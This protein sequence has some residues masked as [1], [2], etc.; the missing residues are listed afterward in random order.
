MKRSRV[1]IRVVMLSAWLALAGCMAW[2]QSAGCNGQA[3]CNETPSL[4][5]TVTSFRTSTSDRTKIVSATV[6]LVNRTDRPLMLGYVTRSGVATDD[7]GNRYV[8]YGQNGVRGIGEIRSNSRFDNKF[9]LPPGG[10][11]DTRFE[12]IWRYSRRD[13]YGEQFSLDLAIREIEPVGTNQYRLGAEHALHFD[14]L[15]N[16]LRTETSA[17]P[18]APAGSAVSTQP[19]AAI[20]ASVPDPCTGKQHCYFAGPF[21]AEIAQITSARVGNYKDHVIRVNVRF[22]NVSSEPLILGYTSG[23]SI[24]TD[25]LGN[26]YYWGSLNTVDK[27]ATGIGTVSSRGANSSFV[28]NPGQ[29]RN[30]TFQLTRYRPGNKPLGTQFTWEV[31]VEQLEVLSPEHVRTTR[32]FALNFTDIQV[33]SYGAASAQSAAEAVQQLKGLFGGG[34]KK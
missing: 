17:T 6:R 2:G 18:V 11:G 14:G 32:E 23:S 30:A 3:F 9:T 21:S 5:A 15:T 19:G 27:S 13:L 26:R 24:M 34:K 29:S 28:L 20:S 33:N 25:E 16:G 10:Y 22:T 12:L 7:R 1:A 8:V 4:L 31:A